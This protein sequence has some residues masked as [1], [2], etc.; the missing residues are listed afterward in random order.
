HFAGPTVPRAVRVLGLHPGE[1]RAALLPSH[2]PQYILPRAVRRTT[3][4]TVGPEQVGVGQGARIAPIRLDP[5]RP[6]CVH[7]GEVRV[8]DGDLPAE[9]LETPG[10]FT[11]GRRCDQDA[12]SVPPPSTAAHRSAS[13]RMRC[14]ISFAPRL[15][16]RF[17]FP[18]CGRRCQY[19]P[20]LA[21]PLC[22]VDRV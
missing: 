11:V 8:R 16:Y 20:W 12:R 22:G 21:S 13:V 4:W 15:R 10:D 9:P 18:S 1:G 7:R 14:S 3:R 19:G 17:D 6:G 5:P 2:G